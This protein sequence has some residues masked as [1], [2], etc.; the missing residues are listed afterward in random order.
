[1]AADGLQS[2]EVESG[3]G[4]E[5]QAGV[6]LCHKPLQPSLLLAWV[7]LPWGLCGQSGLWLKQALPELKQAGTRGKGRAHRRLKEPVKGWGGEACCLWEG[8]ALFPLLSP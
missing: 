5:P 6:S 1:M 8:S 7:F 4:P 3:E 2:V